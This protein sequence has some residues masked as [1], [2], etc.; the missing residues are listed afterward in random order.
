MDLSNAR[1]ASLTVEEK[2]RRVQLE[3]CRFC[4]EAGHQQTTCQKFKCYNCEEIGH[5]KFSCT[6]PR[7]QR[8]QE[9][10]LEVVEGEDSEKE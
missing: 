5:G 10:Q 9:I 4:E 3:L 8:I 7:Q 6:K 1:K 2:A